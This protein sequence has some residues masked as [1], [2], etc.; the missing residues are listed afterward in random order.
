MPDAIVGPACVCR[1]VDVRLQPNGDEVEVG[2]GVGIECGQSLGRIVGD[3]GLGW[4]H[5][6][7]FGS[8]H[9]HLFR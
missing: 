1:A 8:G 9:V 5:D 2:L 6:L 4:R 3:R 7:E